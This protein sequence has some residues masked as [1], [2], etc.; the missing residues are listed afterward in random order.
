LTAKG[1][2][3]YTLSD[4]DLKAIGS[5]GIVRSFPKNAI[6]V[7]EGD[8]TDT[9]YVI[10][11][12]RVKAFVSDSDGRQVVLSTQGPGEYFGELVLDEGPR[13]ASVMTLVPCRFLVVQKEDFR[14]FLLAN[15]AFALNLIEKL[16]AR[17]RALTESVKSLAL[18]DVYGRASNWPRRATAASSSRSA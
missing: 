12:G 1:Q 14:K 3:G 5:H 6:I 7:N 18:M 2:T 15:P 9:L 11:E 17:V 13:S 10:L 16:I 8:S 4:A